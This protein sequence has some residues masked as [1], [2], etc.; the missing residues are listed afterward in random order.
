[1]DVCS[2]SSMS[3]SDCSLLHSSRS[4]SRVEHSSLLAA[5][6]LSRLD[7][8]CS[9]ASLLY[10]SNPCSLPHSSCFLLHCAS[11]SKSSPGNC[12]EFNLSCNNASHSSSCSAASCSATSKLLAVSLAAPN[13]HSSS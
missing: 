13:S 5:I 4:A 12:S 3:F 7:V 2:S 9:D 10:S 1:M 6:R 11:S 8:F